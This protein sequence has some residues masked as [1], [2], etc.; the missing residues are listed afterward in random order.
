[1]NLLSLMWKTTMLFQYTNFLVNCICL[2]IFFAD[3]L[4]MLIEPLITMDSIQYANG[5]DG[6]K[7][8]KIYDQSYSHQAI[9]EYYETFQ[10]VCLF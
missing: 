1:M 4:Y 7:R 8:R 10:R 2:F 5:A 9:T 6:R 3:D